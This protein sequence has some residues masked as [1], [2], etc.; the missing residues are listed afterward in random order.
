MVK[1]RQ[2][3]SLSKAQTK[4]RSKKAHID[5]LIRRDIMKWEWKLRE[6]RDAG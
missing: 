1:Q 2:I 5:P 3:I 6:E 4:I